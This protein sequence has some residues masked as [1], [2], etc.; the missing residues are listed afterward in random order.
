MGQSDL[1]RL[2]IQLD[3]DACHVVAANAA[4]VPWIY[5]HAELE[6]L[7]VVA[8]RKQSVLLNLTETSEDVHAR[9]VHVLH[10]R[11]VLTHIFQDGTEGLAFVQ[12]IRNEVHLSH[13]TKSNQTSHHRTQQTSARINH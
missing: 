6:H 5:R 1:F 13:K 12:A 2:H 7:F 3:D 9:G 8:R 4:S 11:T 10:C